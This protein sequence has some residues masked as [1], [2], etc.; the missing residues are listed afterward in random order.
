[1]RRRTALARRAAL[2]AGL[3]ALAAGLG[4]APA[5]GQVRVDAETEVRA[6]RFTGVRTLSERELRAAIETRDRGSA[7]GLRAALGKLPLVNKPARHAFSPLELQRD[8]VRLRRE[9]RAAGFLRAQVRYEVAR[10]ERQNLLDIVFVVDEGE[11]VHVA[12]VTI[13][14]PDSLA[15]P[16]VPEAERQSWER[17]ERAARKLAGRR[18]DVG[19]ALEERDRLQSWW[20]DRGYPAAAVRG[21]LETDSLRMESRIV[22]RVLPGPRL[23]F[24]DIAVEGNQSISDNVVRRQLPFRPGDVYSA[25]AVDEGRLDVQALEI[26]RVARLEIPELPAADS[27]RAAGPSPAADPLAAAQAESVLPVTVRITE[28]KPRLVSGD[29][30]YVTDAGLSSEA[31]WSHRNFLGDARILTFSGLAQTGLWSISSNPDIRYRGA[32]SVQQPYVA[33]R[34]LSAVLSPFVEY[35]DDSQDRSL[36]YGTNAT[37]VYRLRPQLSGSLDYR[38]ARRHIYEYSLEDLTSGDID[39]LTFLTQLSQGQLDSLGT[40]LLSSVFT[41]SGNLGHLDQIA[42][43]RRGVVVRPA[44]QVT[45]PNAWS[46][47]SYWRL[48]G[49]AYAFAPLARRAI[50]A[51]RL[52]AGRLYPFG[53]SLPGPDQSGTVSFLQLRD[54]TFT[55]GGTGDVRG[56]DSRL[57][58]PKFPDVRFQASGD[59]AV[60]VADGYVPLGGFA[61]VSFS[62]ELRLPLPGFGPKFGSHVFL[63]GGRVWTPD[64][65]F[66]DAG[67][68][69]GQEKFF[70]GAGAGLDLITPVGPI[71]LGV[72][73][74]L[75]PSLTD[76]VDSDD[77]LRARA[78]D[79]PLDQVEKHNSRRWQFYLAI[80]SSF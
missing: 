27:L 33:H 73:Y 38:I 76:L 40:S 8:V 59:T 2:A 53:Q 18:L 56:W 17:A 46:S 29:V 37:L 51:G 71:K 65:R 30:G 58:G 80:G 22:Y 45:A 79:Q 3:V 31:R 54:V 62:L 55:A 50:F 5:A 35:R 4:A 26:V 6:I 61:R 68:R 42:N 14:G 64:Q 21:R 57:L 69:L 34:R 36:Q 19:E 78:E 11:A 39:L 10:D 1:M 77:L 63:D 44:I 72:G 52:A 66:R 49:V 67:D 9:Y 16:S 43:P 60:A 13:T 7:Y 20:R 12:G 28:A 24:G 48:D 25:A 70:Y 23:R 74:K 15:P 41:L 32:V 75:N 47:T